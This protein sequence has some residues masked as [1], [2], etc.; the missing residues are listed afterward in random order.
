MIV[1]KHHPNDLIFTEEDVHASEHILV[2]MLR[3]IFVKKGI[4][5]KILEEKIQEQC[6]KEG[7]KSIRIINSNKYNVL[8]II[9]D[10]KK[11]TWKSF[12]YILQVILGLGIIELTIDCINLDDINQREEKYTVKL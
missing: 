3:H 5:Y 4:T 1:K 12:E 2:K 11:I 8:K 9:K 10:N 6:E 7:I